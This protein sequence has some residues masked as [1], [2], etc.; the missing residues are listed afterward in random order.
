MYSLLLR[1]IPR[2]VFLLLF[3][4]AECRVPAYGAECRGAECR[5][6]TYSAEGRVP[7][8]TNTVYLDIFRII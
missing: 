3:L 8:N 2:R 7:R 5:V 1:Y 4:G 6:P